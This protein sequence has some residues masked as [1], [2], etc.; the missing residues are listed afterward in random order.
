MTSRRPFLLLRISFPRRLI[1][2]QF[3]PAADDSAHGDRAADVHVRHD[4][5]GAV[6]GEE[7]EA[8]GEDTSKC[9]TP[10]GTFEQFETI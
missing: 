1:F 6:G 10:F 9:L 3:P 7:D 8:D 2:V 4:Q 5:V